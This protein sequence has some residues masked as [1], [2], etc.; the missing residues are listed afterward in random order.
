M[1]CPGAFRQPPYSDPWAASS[2]A[3][4]CEC[5]HTLAAFCALLLTSQEDRPL[6][7]LNKSRARATILYL[8]QNSL[9]QALLFRRDFA[10]L[11]LLFVRLKSL[12]ISPM[13]MIVTVPVL[14]VQHS[15]GTKAVF[16]WLCRC[17]KSMIGESCDTEAQARPLS[18][19]SLCWGLGTV[20]GTSIWNSSNMYPIPRMPHLLMGQ[21]RQAPYNYQDASR[22]WLSSVSG[23]QI[24]VLNLTLNLRQNNCQ[25]QLPRS[26]SEAEGLV[27]CRSIT[28]G[29][30]LSAL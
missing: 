23:R 9:R 12:P 8:T 28:R 15:Q 22:F 16:V 5:H 1:V 2:T 10:F 13:R 27:H 20:I 4:S 21:P 24:V 14:F 17:L 29:R 26:M 6:L 19:L 3:P 25:K 30:P 18:I 11:L 7:K